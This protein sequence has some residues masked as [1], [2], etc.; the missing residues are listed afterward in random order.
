M[1]STLTDWQGKLRVA[2]VVGDSLRIL[3]R[4]PV[5]ALLAPTASLTLSGWL[6]Y[7]LDIAGL[8]R[9]LIGAWG[10]LDVWMLAVQLTLAVPTLALFWALLSDSAFEPTGPFRVPRTAQL[11]KATVVATSL[12]LTMLVATFSIGIFAMLLIPLVGTAVPACVCE[13]LGPFGALRRAVSLTDGNRLRLLA[14]WVLLELLALLC[15]L[16]IGVAIFVLA[17]ATNGEILAYLGSPIALLFE[18]LCLAMAAS[19]T[20][21]LCVASY[22]RLRQARVEL[23]VERWVEVFR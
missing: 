3:V 20:T 6:A 12:A 1:Q 8:L 4:R 23:D 10:W 19:V 17:H 13:R 14:A 11:A 18:A 15:S 7:E 5:L 21:T 22:G 16:L 9:P 2:D